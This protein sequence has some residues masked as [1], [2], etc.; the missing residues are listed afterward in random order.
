MVFQRY[1][2]FI[3]LLKSLLGL[4]KS[5]EKVSLYFP[6]NANHSFYD[7]ELYSLS[8]QACFGAGDKFQLN[9]FEHVSGNGN[10]TLPR[11]VSELTYLSEF[12]NITD[13]FVLLNASTDISKYSLLMENGT[14]SFSMLTITLLKTPSTASNYTLLF[15]WL[16][17]S[18]KATTPSFDTA[19]PLPYLAKT[20]CTMPYATIALN[21]NLFAVQLSRCKAATTVG[22][23]PLLD[24]DALMTGLNLT[25]NAYV[26]FD[27]NATGFLSL[28]NNDPWKTYNIPK[29]N[30]LEMVTTGPLTNYKEVYGKLSAVHHFEQD[31]PADPNAPDRL[32]VLGYFNILHNMRDTGC[33]FASGTKCLLC[34]DNYTLTASG[35]CICTPLTS[36]ETFAFPKLNVPWDGPTLVPTS[37]LYSRCDLVESIA[38]STLRDCEKN[39]SLILRKSTAVKMNYTALGLVVTVSV[40][41]PQE[42]FTNLTTSCG[43]PS[44]SIILTHKEDYLSG[45]N[46]Q[47]AL[48]LLFND[49]LKT[50]YSVFTVKTQDIEPFLHEFCQQNPA[51]SEVS[52]YNCAFKVFLGTGPARIT[53]ESYFV[54]HYVNTTTAGQSTLKAETLSINNTLCTKCLNSTADFFLPTIHTF[55]RTE[56]NLTNGTVETYA[57]KSYDD[58]FAPKNS[59]P[60]IEVNETARFTVTLIDPLMN[61]RYKYLDHSVELLI[62]DKMKAKYI[63]HKC[64]S[65][66]PTVDSVFQFLTLECTFEIKNNVTL[67]ISLNLK[68]ADNYTSP[69]YLN[70]TNV[71]Q[72]E[73]YA[74][75][76]PLPDPWGLGYKYTLIVIFVVLF[77]MV[78]F[79]CVIASK[80]RYLGPDGIPVAEDPDNPKVSPKKFD[81]T[82]PFSKIG[83]AIKGVF[84]KKQKN[85]KEEP[86]LEKDGEIE[87][88]EK[89]IPKTAKG[90]PKKKK[91]LQ[92][93]VED[94]LG[95][96]SEIKPVEDAKKGRDFSLNEHE[97]IDK[98]F[99]KSTGRAKG[100][101]KRDILEM[102]DNSTPNKKDLVKSKKK[103]TIDLDDEEDEVDSKSRNLKGNKSK[104]KVED[105]DFDE[106]KPKK[107]ILAPKKAVSRVE[108]DD[109]DEEEE[110]ERKRELDKKARDKLKRQK[111]DEDD[112]DEEEDSK[113]PRKKG[114]LDLNSGKLAVNTSSASTKGNLS[115]SKA[116]D[117]ERFSDDEDK[118]KPKPKDIR[119]ALPNTSLNT[120]RDA[121]KRKVREP[122]P[123]EDPDEIDLEEELNRL[124]KKKAKLDAMRTKPKTKPKPVIEEDEEDEEEVEQKPKGKTK[125]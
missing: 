76:V 110:V 79:I 100:K 109:D 42:N 74:I 112:E 34:H 85:E 23:M 2:Q 61:M 105:D 122:E 31:Q 114:L 115:K 102:L 29:D 83:G 89:N 21:L 68:A 70:T 55:N 43:V 15:D 69:I 24:S 86:L 71:F 107:K 40:Y 91:P 125:R 35:D 101:D 113:L 97:D 118:P 4:A 47:N 16:N 46:R 18:C 54:M 73:V 64:N 99:E 48:R 3:L 50:N 30:S 82:T 111:K 90:A 26:V 41:H 27:K 87:S 57:R 44:A 45:R 77:L 11:L 1:W 53:S 36:F 98:M 66:T 37:F 78:T 13:S 12:V 52:R 121:A 60:A 75:P 25:V 63:G 80:S 7:K 59:T 20:N 119:K 19:A 56:F 124:D 108:E 28:F 92:T 49:T 9:Y 116:Q 22:G 120:S 67:N 94:D 117:P 95:D 8:D 5:M 39:M 10:Q 17:T 81:I 14:L 123:E 62:P 104:V 84:A 33:K 51:K 6:G 93:A 96:L 106:E 65:T 58:L 32:F 72:F 38:N 88:E 103:L